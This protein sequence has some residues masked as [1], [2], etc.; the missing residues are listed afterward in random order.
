MK[1][2]REAAVYTAGPT[3]AGTPEEEKSK[4]KIVMALIRELKR[5][6]RV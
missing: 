5:R 3:D 1:H 4:C 2:L 6:S